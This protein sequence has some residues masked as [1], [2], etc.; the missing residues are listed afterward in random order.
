MNDFND[1][2]KLLIGV[3]VL[4]VIYL[5]FFKNNHTIERFEED[6]LT[7]RLEQALN[8]NQFNTSQQQKQSV[9]ESKNN[10]VCA[11]CLKC[12]DSLG[13][14][15][16]SVYCQG[17]CF[18]AYR[19]PDKDHLAI[20]IIKEQ[21]SPEDNNSKV[22]GRNDGGFLTIGNKEERTNYG[23]VKRIPMNIRA[24]T[25]S[26]KQIFKMIPVTDKTNTYILQSKEYETR[27]LTYNTQSDSYS[28]TISPLF[29][30]SL[31]QEWYFTNEYD[32]RCKFRPYGSITST[33]AENLIKADGESEV[34]NVQDSL[35]DIMALL[36][37]KK[38]TVNSQSDQTEKL[39][40]DGK[41]I[42]LDFTQN[43]QGL[44]IS[45]ID[46]YSNVKEGFEVENTNSL[47]EITKLKEL[48]KKSSCPS[49]K[50]YVSINDVAS[51]N[52][53]I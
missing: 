53:N 20:Y 10:E 7:K 44:S 16:A 47:E 30:N 19:L 41:R 26:S 11:K 31:N 24:Y 43:E 40:I 12:E 32:E 1:I 39:D 35:K 27:Y 6:E 3:I 51:C 18:D 13:N 21:E 38:C 37:N 14:P 50:D 49:L 2:N 45:E 9:G 34:I 52:C 28:L 23:M 46:G 17:S 33:L 15:N 22:K 42:T 5:M 36:K 8:T 4:L 29:P 25:G 48:V